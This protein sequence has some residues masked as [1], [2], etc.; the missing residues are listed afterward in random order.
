MYATQVEYAVLF[1]QLACGLPLA[2]EEAQDRKISWIT[3]Q[4]I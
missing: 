1:V 4:E 2:N 3:Q